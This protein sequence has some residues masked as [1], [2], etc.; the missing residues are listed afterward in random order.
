MATKIREYE[1]ITYVVFVYIYKMGKME[2]R[3]ENHATRVTKIPK[4]ENMG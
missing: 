4:D 2:K 3:K 1:N